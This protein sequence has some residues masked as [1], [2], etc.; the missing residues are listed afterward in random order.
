MAKPRYVKAEPKPELRIRLSAALFVGCSLGLAG[1][2]AGILSALFPEQRQLLWLAISLCMAGIAGLVSY[3]CLERAKLSHHWRIMT[4]AIPAAVCFGL[5]TFLASHL[6]EDKGPPDFS[7]VPIKRGTMRVAFYG[8][9][10]P[11]AL[12]GGDDVYR[13]NFSCALMSA[14]TAP[15]PTG[16]WT[17]NSNFQTC[18]IFIVWKRPIDADKVSVDMDGNQIF[19]SKIV[20]N[21]FYSP[22]IT[23]FVINGV[24][25]IGL[26]TISVDAKS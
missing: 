21:E 11:P 19:S 15:S 22:Y 16:P 8:P 20:R 4:A 2:V 23:F 26:M 24:P 1:I 14:E 9:Q 5:L 25:P 17:N 12:I 13:P 18:S 3:Y 6:I 7:S 10:K